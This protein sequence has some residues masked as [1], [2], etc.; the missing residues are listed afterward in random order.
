MASDSILIL[1]EDNFDDQVGLVQGPLLV[2]FWAAWCAPCRALAPVLDQLG[3]E[4]HGQATL[5]KV[6]VDDHGDLANRFGIRSIPTLLVFLNGKVVDQM[7]GAAPKDQI[8]SMV[9]RHVAA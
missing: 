5:A 8:R 2:D 7:I 1:T 6:N 4:L 9:L 3:D